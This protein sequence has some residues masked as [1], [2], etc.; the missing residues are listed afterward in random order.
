MLRHNPVIDWQLRLLQFNSEN[1]IGN[2]CVEPLSL[3]INLQSLITAHE[4]VYPHF[5]PILESS[6]DIPDHLPFSVIFEKET[7]KI[8]PEN[9]IYDCPIELAPGST[10]PRGKMYNL[11]VPETEALSIWLDDMIE[12]GFIRKSASPFAA[13]IFFV[14]K[15]DGSLRPCNDYRKLNQQTVRDCYPIP[16]IADLLR[17]IST[18]VIF[19]LMDL[20][21]A[22]N[23]LRMRKGDEYKT[24]FVC[25]FGQYEF[26]VMPF[27]LMNA[28]SVFQAMMDDILKAYSDFAIAYLDDIIIFSAD[29]E[30]HKQHLEIV[31]GLLLKHTFCQVVKMSLLLLIN[32]LSWL[33]RI[34]LGR[35]HGSW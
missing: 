7:A 1:C 31:C 5:D 8:L 35:V 30:S 15:S 22:F 17:R 34:F 29:V 10:P 24:S 9:R 28:P 12:R 16:L 33:Y 21:G 4:S 27:G 2:C 19:S 26:L 18:G 32:L 13:P 23:L 3:T 20:Y 11:T 6:G 14:S 25:K